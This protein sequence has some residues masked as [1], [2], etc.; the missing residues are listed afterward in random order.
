MEKKGRADYEKLSH[1]YVE[2]RE[3]Q[4]LSRCLRRVT[5]VRAESYARTRS[6]RK[7]GRTF[8]VRR[9]HADTRGAVKAPPPLARHFRINDLSK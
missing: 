6:E 8:I 2:Y 5:R 3:I 9:A 4:A 7:G 1:G